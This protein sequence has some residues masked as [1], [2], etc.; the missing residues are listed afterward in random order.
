MVAL[1]GFALRVG[2]I[3]VIGPKIVFG[4]DALWYRIQASTLADGIGFVNVGELVGSGRVVP[5]AAFP[6]L[7][8]LMLSVVDR[9]GGTSDWS[10]QLAGALAGTATI[11]LTAYVGRALGGRAIGLAAAAVVAVSPS[12]IAADGSLM[13]ESLFVALMSLATLVALRATRS[14]SGWWWASLGVV[15]A[16]ATL[17]RSDALFLAP[18]LVGASVLGARSLTTPRRWLAAGTALLVFAVALA[19]W[20]VSRSTALDTPILVTSNSGTLME[21]ANCPRTYSGAGLGLWDF[22]CLTPP[23]PGVS[24]AKAAAAGRSAGLEY[25]TDHLERLPL[26]GVVRAL[27]LWGLYDPIDQARGEETV[28][29]RQADWQVLAWAAFIVTLGFAVAGFVRVRGRS[30]EFAPLLAL[31]VGVTFVGIVSWGNQRFRL[32]AE[33]AIAVYAAVAVVALVRRITRPAVPVA[34]AVGD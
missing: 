2:Y 31:I 18:I 20:I 15:L 34:E 21:G 30:A 5:T 3:A 29:S 14:D 11:V 23:Q 26:V 27:R 33:P 7:W 17:T 1:L 19:P 16:L 9:L 8:P 24:E 10:F 28:E 12:L 4:A 6:P 25:A 22:R 13:S 32:A